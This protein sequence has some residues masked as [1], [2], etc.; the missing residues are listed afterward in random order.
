MSHRIYESTRSKESIE[1]HTTRL[2]TLSTHNTIPANEIHDCILQMKHSQ[3]QQEQLQM[4]L[5]PIDVPCFVQNGCRY[6]PRTRHDG[7]DGPI[8][9]SCILMNHNR[10][11]LSP[12]CGQSSTLRAT[13]SIS[14]ALERR[15]SSTDT[16]VYEIQRSFKVGLLNYL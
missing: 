14:L 11:I 1:Q 13:L 6:L 3:F 15:Q 4:Q 7:N 10:D 9:V 2:K 8:V 16:N 5:S 12:R